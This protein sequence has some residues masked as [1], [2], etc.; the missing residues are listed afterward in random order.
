MQIEL[1]I[2][3]CWYVIKTRIVV[4]ISSVQKK[5][6]ITD[7]PRV[8]PFVVRLHICPELHHTCSD[9][10]D[11]KKIIRKKKRVIYRYAQ[12]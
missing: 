12:W 5:K 7:M 1:K 10:D 8:N 11:T 6:K 2:E 9:L 3:L 4:K